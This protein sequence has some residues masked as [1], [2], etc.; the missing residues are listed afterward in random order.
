MSP[1][2]N[3]LYTP[4]NSR[5]VKSNAGRMYEQKVLFWSMSK[6]RLL[7]EI[8]TNFKSKPLRVD[9]TFV[10]PKSRLVTKKDTLKKIDYSNRLKASMD[11]LAKIINIDDSY[12][13]CGMAKK[14]CGPDDREYINIIISVSELENV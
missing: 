9:C 11:M 4:I 2:S 3:T 12:F 6:R 10:F 7:E 13:V 1:T 8:A 5:L 14:A